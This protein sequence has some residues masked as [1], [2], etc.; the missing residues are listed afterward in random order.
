ML[1]AGHA[2][3]NAPQ[4][5]TVGELARLP[6]Y[7]PD[8]QLFETRGSPNAPT[9]R[10]RHWV[11]V[12]GPTFWAV[13]H[14][15]WAVLNSNRSERAGVNAQ[16]REFLLTTAVADG[17]YVLNNSTADFPL[18]PEVLHRVG[19]YNMRLGRPIQ[20]LE[21]FEKSKQVK[22]DYW[23]PYLG[24]AEVNLQL[25]RRQ[26]AIDSLTEG[27]KAV[28]NEPSLKRA[29]DRISKPGGTPTTSQAKPASARP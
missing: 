6:E 25:G 3:A 13:H 11:S 28:P 4:N 24:I 23:P 2:A 18:L 21:H 15:C 16:Q 29:L 19:E 10:Q 1:A 9:D 26:L 17:Y 5:I 8:A 12:M 14:Y 20:A 27:L 22:F 7:C